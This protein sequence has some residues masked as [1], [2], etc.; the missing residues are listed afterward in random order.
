MTAI[1]V[2]A[3]MIG[4]SGNLVLSLGLVGALS[5]VR[6]RTAIKD[7]EELTHLFLCIAI[8]LGFGANERL[9]TSLGGLFLL[10]MLVLRSKLTKSI[11]QEY[12]NLSIHSTSLNID[13]L[14]KLINP[15]CKDVNLRRFDDQNNEIDVLFNVDI[16][17]HNQLQQLINAVKSQDNQ[18]SISFIENR[19]Y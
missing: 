14:I 10:L 15:F 19:S 9:V 16:T 12:Y 4:I 6:F 3:L 11:T 13:D 7:P 2:D 17:N 8:G 18:A 1:I 5:I